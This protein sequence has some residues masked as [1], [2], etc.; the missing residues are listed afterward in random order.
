M[1]HRFTFEVQSLRR[2]DL[3]TKLSCNNPLTAVRILRNT[4]SSPPTCILPIIPP[5]GLYAEDSATSLRRFEISAPM[6]ARQSVPS[7]SKP[8][9]CAKN[10][11]EA[12]QERNFFSSPPQKRQSCLG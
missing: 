10:T 12:P 3:I 5:K 2:G 9:S 4:N 11:P 1:I 6:T 8:A 7:I